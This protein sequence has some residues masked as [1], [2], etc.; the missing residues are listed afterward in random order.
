MAASPALLCAEL[1]LPPCPRS[2][3][4]GTP[5]PGSPPHWSRGMA[6]SPTVAPSA[7]SAVAARTAGRC[8][9]LAA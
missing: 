2:P 6:A 1:R 3:A 8:C 5:L 4:P 7:A 9:V